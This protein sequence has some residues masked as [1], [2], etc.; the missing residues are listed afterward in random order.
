MNFVNK[1][2]YI[3]WPSTL[4]F[5]YKIDKIYHLFDNP[6]VQDAGKGG[7]S[8]ATF[9]AL[10]FDLNY[11]DVPGIL[12]TQWLLPQPMVIKRGVGLT[13]CLRL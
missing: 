7:G 10:N 8:V 13:E 5:R 12:M 3:L 11:R 6:S 1:C 9:G 2:I 4:S